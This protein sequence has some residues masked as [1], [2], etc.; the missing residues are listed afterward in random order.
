M[1]GTGLPQPQAVLG[2]KG[3][4]SVN[5]IPPPAT[6][7]EPTWVDANGYLWLYGG[8][9][10]DYSA[11]MWRYDIS[12]N[13]WTWM[14]GSDTGFVPSYGTL[15]VE[16]ASNTPGE[17]TECSATW[18]DNENN[19]WLYGG[20]YDFGAPFGDLWK[21]NTSTNNWTWMGG[22]DTLS[23]KAVYGTLGVPAATNTPGGRFAWC[24]WQ[25]AKGDFWL[26]GGSSDDIFISYNDMWRY[27]GNW[28]WMAGTDTAGSSGNYAAACT[29]ATN[30]EAGA[31]MENRARWKDDCGNFW[32][33]GAG[34]LSQG[35]TNDLWYFNPVSLNW[36][37]VNGGNTRVNPHFS[38][39]GVASA[40]NTP[41][42]R[43]SSTPW[44]SKTGELYF[45]WRNRIRIRDVQ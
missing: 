8:G 45:F 30:L 31:R 39:Q 18:I 32:F 16:S 13:S 1:K 11:L 14:Q 3:V 42:G 43:Q 7:E 2:T 33:Y 5:N 35:I 9:G 23:A 41:G 37:I 15:G 21:Y 12:S 17:R 6:W 34:V 22:S 25:D 29:G 38:A 10:E 36:T 44:Y 24:S 27:D 28:T 19:L 20:D 26:F 4:P 40:A